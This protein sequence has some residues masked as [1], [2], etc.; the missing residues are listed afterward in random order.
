MPT[1]TREYDWYLELEL[2]T[3]VN[4]S[5]GSW[6]PNLGPVPKQYSNLLNHLSSP[7]A[8]FNRFLFIF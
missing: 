1:E 7:E 6:E 2:L 3:V 5:S 4:P 8:L